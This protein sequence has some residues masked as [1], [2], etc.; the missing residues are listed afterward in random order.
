MEQKSIEQ[1]YPQVLYHYTSYE[2]FK[3]ILQFGT[4]R[5]KL[6]TQSNDLL[7]TNYIVKLI[8]K[9]KFF[10]EK[11][12]SEMEQLLKLLLGYFQREEYVNSRNSFVACFTSKPD[13]RLLWDAYTINRPTQNKCELGKE[14]YCQE[15]LATYNGVCI[16][17]KRDEIRKILMVRDSSTD[18]EK[19]YIMPIY[20][21][22][23]Q[24]LAALDYYANEAWSIY[25]KVK[26]EPDQ[27]QDIVPPFISGFQLDFGEYKG[28]PHYQKISLKRCFVAAMFS[29][30]ENIETT[31]PIFK[32]QF[33]E[34]EQ[35]FRAV[36]CRKH[37]GKNAS[38]GVGG[39]ADNQY[40][41]VPITGNIIEHLI[42]G[43]TFSDIEAE[44]LNALESPVIKFNELKSCL[45]NGSGIITMR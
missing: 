5:F 35:E 20:Y 41:D 26:Q 23:E 44:Q 6:S 33:W 28:K 36:L 32:H 17:F 31:A 30:I 40:I 10:N 37:S 14:K 15:A 16:G 19:A 42:L 45:S 18:Y 38:N 9:I 22:E 27:S 39:T 4:M 7:D 11:P 43:P 2:K 29:F 34:E 3:C 8:Q 13:S 12:T 21:S 1:I 24:Q 25:E